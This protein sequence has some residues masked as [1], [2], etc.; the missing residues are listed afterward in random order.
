[1]RRFQIYAAWLAIIS[2]LIEGLLPTAVSA[3]TRFGESQSPLPLCSASAGAP[4]HPREAPPLPLRH[5]ALCTVCS[6]SL[7]FL[8]P[9]PAGD[10]I[11][12]DLLAGAAYPRLL[13][14]ARIAR[15]RALYGVAQPRAPPSAFS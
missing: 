5:C 3:A 4:A 6:G 1:M 14:S 7:A 11:A 8:S 2:L 15:G 9:R 12:S 10:K 13:L